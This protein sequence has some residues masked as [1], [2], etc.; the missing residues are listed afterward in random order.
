[1]HSHNF[2]RS[3]KHCLIYR[4]VKVALLHDPVTR[5][6][7][8]MLP[9]WVLAETRKKREKNVSHVA[10]SRN[11]YRHIYMHCFFCICSYILTRNYEAL[12]KGMKGNISGFV[13]LMMELKKCCN[14]T[15]LVIEDDYEVDDALEVCVRFIVIAPM[16]GFLEEVLD[17]CSI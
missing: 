2:F 1:M 12:A 10:S 4:R 13:N 15:S 11:N 16:S 3:C 5:Q 17:K 7:Q 6:G 9:T 14:H 8:G